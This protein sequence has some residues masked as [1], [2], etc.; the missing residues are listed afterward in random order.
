[1]F[2]LLQMPYTHTNGKCSYLGHYTIY[3]EQLGVRDMVVVKQIQMPLRVLGSI[4]MRQGFMV[5]DRC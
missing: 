5:A 1:M 3:D 4:Q 2:K